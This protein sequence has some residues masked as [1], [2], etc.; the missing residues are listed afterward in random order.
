MANRFAQLRTVGRDGYDTT[1]KD[2]F[3]NQVVFTLDYSDMQLGLKEARQ[4]VADFG[5]ELQA[6]MSGVKTQKGTYF[7]YADS[8]FSK[9]R[10]ATSMD[11]LIPK[12]DNM[13]NVINEFGKGVSM[14]SKEAIKKYIGSR[15]DTGLMKG[16]VYGR[17][18]KSKGK[19]V[20]RAGWLDIWYKY[21]GYQE[22]GTDTIRPMHAILRTYLEIA[23][24]VQRGM[25]EF[26]RMSTR[27]GGFKE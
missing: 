27:K 10:T 19:I 24:Q 3:D 13:D 14:M 21:F 2:T 20:S 9:A 11:L 8:D 17:T 1:S 4:M 16:S 7:V 26:L 6:S 25:S 15:V 5:K 18:T 22:E 12:V 23:P